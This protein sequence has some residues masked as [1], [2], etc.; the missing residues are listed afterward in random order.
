MPTCKHSLGATSAVAT[1]ATAMQLMGAGS[2]LAE[3]IQ[4][5]VV[6]DDPKELVVRLTDRNRGTVSILDEA[7]TARP[8]AKTLRSNTSITVEG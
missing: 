2:T 4:A 8:P 6:N 7:K 3:Q 1:A 5:H